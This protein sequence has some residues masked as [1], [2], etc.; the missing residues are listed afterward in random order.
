[1]ALRFKSLRT[2]LILEFCA[3]AII[4]LLVVLAMVVKQTD[5]MLATA[6]SESLELAYADLD[7]TVLGMQAM[8]TAQQ[9]L[10]EMNLRHNLNVARSELS[11]AGLVST[12]PD[13]ARWSATNQFTKETETIELPRMMVGD[14]WL[15]QNGDIA[16]ATPVIDDVEKLVG[17]TATV[18]QRMNAAGDMLRVA[19]NVKTKAEQRAIGT[20]IPAVNPDGSRNTVVATVVSGDTYTGRAYVVNAWYISAYEP[21][22]TAEGEIIGMLYVGVR[23]DSVSAVADSILQTTVGQTGQAY[24]L[25]GR[26]QYVLTRDPSLRG[27]SALEAEDA[28]G[29]GPMA[30]IVDI[31]K[32]L[33]GKR[34]GSVRYPT[35]QG[36]RVARFVRF[37]PWNWVI[38]AE[39][40]ESEFLA[41]STKIA[42]IGQRSIWVIALTAVIVALVAGAAGV[43]LSRRLTRPVI[44]AARQLESFA[45]GDLSTRDISDDNRA[46]E[47]GALARA[48]RASAARLREVIGTVQGA[49]ESVAGG[50]LQLTSNADSLSQAAASQA[51]TAQ[52]VSASMQQIRKLIEQNTGHAKGAAELSRQVRDAATSSQ[53]AVQEAVDAMGDISEGIVAIQRIARQTSMLALNAAIEAARAGDA[54]KGFAV[55]AME[56]SRLAEHAEKSAKEITGLSA[57]SAEVATRA[58]AM[59]DG[60]LPRLTKLLDSA[61]QVSVA[62]LEQNQSAEEVTRAV[63]DLDR[64]VQHNASSSEQLVA[65]SEELSARAHQLRTSTS[66]FR[67]DA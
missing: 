11:R 64:L 46:D 60:L 49:A 26:G 29:G 37:A 67:A 39:A 24:V 59:I 61:D 18:F 31:A 16:V 4:P 3:I 38:V 21:I 13:T 63:G 56:V 32:G 41:A 53:L 52:Q 43:V 36:D 66:Y 10:L 1:M 62:S 47:L 19:T 33:E 45:A 65:T 55:V 5:A 22:K 44:T 30:A 17:G 42:S 40:P 50:S 48:L 15:G 9:S 34:V 8:V 6:K 51:A 23:E 14:Q 27:R 25:D 20:Y 35:E 58:A 7:H 2:P 57:R 12:G 54:G 28:A